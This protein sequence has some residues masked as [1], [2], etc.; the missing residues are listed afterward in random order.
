MQLIIMLSNLLHVNRKIIKAKLITRNITVGN[1][2]L[3]YLRWQS[4]LGLLIS[5]F[6]FEPTKENNKPINSV[7]HQMKMFCWSTPSEG[8][9]PCRLWCKVGKH[10]NT[11]CVVNKVV[12][13]NL[14]YNYSGFII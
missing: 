7:C 4:I 6:N 10:S 2:S 14:I 12:L 9:L 8:R 3:T 5:R 11:S 1:L 13:G